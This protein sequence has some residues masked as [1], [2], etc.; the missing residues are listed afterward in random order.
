MFTYINLYVWY[1][2]PFIGVLTWI[3]RPFINKFEVLKLATISTLA[4]IYTIPWSNYLAYH[5]VWSHSPERVLAVPVEKYVFLALQNILTGL[6]TLLCVR[7]SLPC[8]SF[9][10]D[11]QSYQF[12]RWIPILLMAVAT[13]AGHVMAIPGKNT[14]Y[15]GCILLWISPVFIILW[16]GAGN[17]F[18]KK[19]VSSSVSILVPTLYQCYVDKLLLKDAVLLTTNFT[20]L[21]AFISKDLLLED[22]IFFF[23][24]N[25]LIVLAVNGFDKSR[26]MIDTYLPE[27]PVRFG[28]NWK[29]NCQL[30]RAFAT[31]E[32]CMPSIVTEDI[33][34]IDKIITASSKSFWLTNHFFHPGKLKLNCLKHSLS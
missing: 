14:F 7:W 4:V 21:N 13:V 26:G 6:W 30:F 15:L 11:K 9:N 32:Y 2:L 8:L 3:N 17:F 16:Y 12:V 33:R 1:T 29:F 22:A 34:K 18:A 28:F 19:M 25:A 24:T 31:P 10:H 20:N 5:G 27:F 23:V